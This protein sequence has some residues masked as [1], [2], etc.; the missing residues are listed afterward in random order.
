MPYERIGAVSGLQLS[1]SRRQLA[2]SYHI[3][4][5]ALSS[6]KTVSTLAH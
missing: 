3:L 5:A 4:C 1:H 2:R 6:V